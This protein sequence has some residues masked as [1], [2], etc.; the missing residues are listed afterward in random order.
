MAVSRVL[1]VINSS[2]E[3]GGARHV[4]ALVTHMD[5][6]RFEPVV[7]TTAHGPLVQRLQE[8]GVRVVAVNM[9]RGRLDPRPVLGLRRLMVREVF[10]LVHLHG[11][12]AGFFGTLALGLVSCRPRVIYTVHGLSCSRTASAAVKGLFARVERFIAHR[13][14]RVISV[15]EHDRQS[16][17]EAG[18]LPPDR[19]TSIPNGICVGSAVQDL[20]PVRRTAGAAEILV[21][22]RL[23]RQKGIPVLLE[24]ARIVLQSHPRSRFTLA[25]D[26]PLRAELEEEAE[27][28]GISEKVRFLGTVADAGELLAHCDLF[29]LPSLWEGMPL[30]LLEA[31]AAGRPAVAT[32]VSGSAE[33]IL[34]EET[35]LLVPPGDAMAL[36]VAM[37]RLLQNPQAAAA[38][39]ARAQERVRREFSLERMVESTHA[40]YCNLLAEL[41]P[42]R[43]GVRQVRV[44]R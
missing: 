19:T 9:M 27:R 36:A 28:L 5:R 39:G 15:S 22:G 20:R 8:S 35:G 16:G 31:M 32:A 25:G 12:R 4:H 17:V 40:L 37:A 33:L 21:V 10:D 3:G 14:H 2:E 34:D 41:E 23:V 38:M 42:G 26:G 43:V 18:L 24:A 1:H 44:L 7:A 13:V 30:S 11:T 29:V 6:K